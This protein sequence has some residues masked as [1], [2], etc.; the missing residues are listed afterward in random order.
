MELGSNGLQNKGKAGA[1]PTNIDVNFNSNL[2]GQANATNPLNVNLTDGVNPVTPTS[3]LLTGNDLDIVIPPLSTPSGVLFKTIEPSQY[4]SYRTGD[5]GW[6]VQ[7]GWFDYTPPTNPAAVAELDFTSANALFVLANPL[8]V[9]GVS[10]TT[11]FVDV[12]GIQAFSA[13]GNANLVIIDKLT[14]LMF[15]RTSVTGGTWDNGI[16]AALALIYTVNSMVLDDWF[17]YSKLEAQ[18][19]YNGQTDTQTSVTL[20]ATLA[21]YDTWVS[22]T[23][24]SNTAQSFYFNRSRRVPEV[25]TKTTAGVPIV[26]VRNA[27]NLI[28]AP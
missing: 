11:R 3:V 2:E 23:N 24:P 8:V 26:A 20:F 21:N 10:S 22:S 13:T 7:N 1:G 19:M 5:E 14:G 25:F 6:R 9:N 16:D 15:T 4:T 18:S 27:R 17:L 28:T 12:N